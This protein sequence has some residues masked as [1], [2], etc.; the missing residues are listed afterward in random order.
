MLGLTDP[1][2]HLVE[3]FVPGRSVVDGP[4]D[5]VHQRQPLGPQRNP[6]LQLFV[7]PRQQIVGLL[8][9]DDIGRVVRQQIQPGQLR[10]GEMTGAAVVR[11]N[12]SQ[13]PTCPVE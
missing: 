1:A 12:P 2:Q 10:F 9:L 6:L 11:R 13:K 5:V 7:S 8:A 3:T 4:R